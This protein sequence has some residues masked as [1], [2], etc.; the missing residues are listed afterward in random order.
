[1]TRRPHKVLLLAATLKNGGL[2]RQLS[3]LATNLSAAWAPAVWTT[4]GGPF[5]EVLSSAG[6]PV[7]LEERRGRTDPGPFARLAR[8][9]L[10]HR[11]DVVHA[12]HW[13]PAAVAAPVCR[14]AGI[15]FIDGTIRL[16]SPNPEFGRPRAGTMRLASLVVANSHAGLDA[17]GVGADRGRVVCNAFDPARR[18]LLDA[19]PTAPDVAAAETGRP[20]TVVMTGRMEPQKD[21]RGLIAAAR[22]LVEEDGPG[23][24]RFVLVGDGPEAEVLRR[25]AADLSAAG[26]VEFSSPGLEVLPVVRSADAGVLLTDAA[27]HAEG[28]S[29]SIMEYMACGLPVVAVDDGGNRELVEDGVSGLLVPGGDPLAVAGALAALR[30]GGDVRS[31]MGEAGRSRLFRDF[32]LEAMVRAYEDIYQECL[33]MCR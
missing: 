28:C 12:W 2:E 14:A 18:T 31:R 20:F 22:L 9:I 13:M 15:P 16:G 23:A 30:T 21:F 1:V 32:S 25:E 3:L 7:V 8:G 5:L 11:P 4:E 19:L 27:L 33:A 10:R 29:N 17:W 24:W 26:V 6:V